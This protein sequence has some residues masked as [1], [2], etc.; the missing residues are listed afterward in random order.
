MRS[1]GRRS[2]TLDGETNDSSDARG[3][4]SHRRSSTLDAEALQTAAERSQ[5]RMWRQV[6]EQRRA[7]GAG[8]G[9]GATEASTGARRRQAESTDFSPNRLRSWI[10]GAMLLGVFVV[11]AVLSPKRA[12]KASPFAS[13]TAPTLSSMEPGTPVVAAVPGPAG[14][15]AAAAPAAPGP[16]PAGAAPVAVA[17]AAPAGQAPAAPTSV[18]QPSAVAPEAVAAPTP[19]PVTCVR[20]LVV[21]PGAYMLDAER[22]D[23]KRVK[24]RVLVKG[25]SAYKVTCTERDCAAWELGPAN[26]AQAHI[27]FQG[28]FVRGSF[29]GRGVLECVATR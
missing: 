1:S 29:E 27:I 3:A 13:I 2:R 5:E 23:G 22:A 18:F 8:A 15:G 25:G 19:L 21:D 9:A 12:E 16:A 28:G 4:S 14:G 24:S 10:V 26:D 20:T 17:A 6:E 7:M 11:L